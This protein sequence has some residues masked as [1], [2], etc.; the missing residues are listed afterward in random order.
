MKLFLWVNTNSPIFTLFC[1]NPKVSVIINLI[2]LYDKFD[3]LNFSANGGVSVDN[4]GFC[5]KVA[6]PAAN[7][8][9]TNDDVSSVDHV[10]ELICCPC[11]CIDFGNLDILLLLSIASYNANS[12]IPTLVLPDIF[13]PMKT[14]L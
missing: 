14:N 4:T 5:G 11:I 3:W 12:P 6:P 13:W 1:D 9:V 10:V 2:F 7:G 8:A